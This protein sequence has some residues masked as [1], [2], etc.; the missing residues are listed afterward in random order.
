MKKI[1]ISAAVAAMAAASIFAMRA[2]SGTV[3]R[4]AALGDIAIIDFTGFIDGEEFE[5]GKGS[6]YQLGLGSGSFIPGFEDQIIG[7]EE[8]DEF[9]VKVIFPKDYHFAPL[10]GKPAVFRVVLHQIT[11]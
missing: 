4:K 2:P 7:H 9:D 5:G 10:A 6:G 3:P 11:S 8:G 1:L